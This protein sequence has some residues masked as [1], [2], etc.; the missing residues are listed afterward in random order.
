[1]TR[2]QSRVGMLA[3]LLVLTGVTA[4]SAEPAGLRVS[5]SD[6]SL[7]IREVAPLDG[8][9]RARLPDRQ[10]FEPTPALPPS[11]VAPLTRQT[12]SGRIGAAGWGAPEKT[13]P[14]RGAGD[15]DGG[16]WLGVGIVGEWGHVRRSQN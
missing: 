3:G 5:P 12:E 14:S 16:G 11:F 15:V 13:I 1:M 2:S 7:R 4:L 8:V 10:L 6:P 9:G